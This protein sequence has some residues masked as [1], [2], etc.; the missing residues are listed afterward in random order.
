[1]LTLQHQVGYEQ[2]VFPRIP[3]AKGICGRV[4]STGKPVLLQ[5]VHT[6][7]EFLAA[8]EDIV[9]EVC[10][11]L[12]DQGKV[13]GVLNVETTEGAVLGDDDLRMMTSLSEQV[14]I[15]ISKAR[16]FSSLTQEK[17]RLELLYHLA[18]QLS[19]SLDM[20]QIAQRATDGI[21]AFTGASGGSVM[22]HVEDDRM[23]LVAFSGHSE[24]INSVNERY[25]PRIGKGLTSWVAAHQQ[26]ALVDDVT[27]DE[28]WLFVPGL[29]DVTRS[30]IS[31]PLVSGDEL[32]GVLSFASDRVAFFNQDHLRL[33]ESAATG[34]A[35]AIANARLYQEATRSLARL[36]ALSEISRAVSSSLDPAQ[37]LTT[38]ARYAAEL[39]NSD[40]AGIFEYDQEEQR[41]FISASY[42]T[43][44]EFTQ[45]VNNANIKIGQGA[46]GQAAATLQPAQ[47]MDTQ[48]TPNY[49]YSQ[50][51]AIE[52]YCSI[53][54]VPMLSRDKLL[55]GIVLWREHRK[56]F[57]QDAIEL[58]SIL[59]D[60]SVVAI[61]NARLYREASRRLKEVSLIQS[62]AL[63]GA[64]GYPF[65]DI[66]DE[67]T[68][69]I[70][71]LWDSH[72]LGFLFPDETGA[73][74]M[75]PSYCG[76]SVE[77][78]QALRL[79]PGEG[80]T[81]WAFQRAQAVVVSN[82]RQDPR[83][84][85]TDS[86]TL[87]EMDAPL[88]VGERPIGVVNVESQR[89]NAF[90]ISDLQLLSTLAGQLAV[91]LDNAQ[92]HRD[93]ADRARQLEEAYNRLAEAEELKDQLVQN[94]SHE[95][96]TP[97]TYIKGYTEL[98]L[99]EAFGTL[100]PALRE[101][102]ETVNQKT[103]AVARLVRRIV[104]L[105]AMNPL[106]LSLEPLA[107]PDLLGEATESW[108]LQAQRSDIEI[109]LD[110][111][112]QL[113]PIAGDRKQ[114]LEAFDNLFSNAIKFS[115]RGGQVHVTAHREAELVHIALSDTGIGIP[116]DKLSR[117]FDR[118]YQVDGTT[119]RRFG[120]AGVGLALVRQIVE[121]HG[122]H[123]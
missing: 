95:L 25:Q 18:R 9:S 68:D 105:Q 52:N 26:S 32:V 17:S 35:V 59:A 21:R 30:A 46:I 55:G 29:G 78:R 110:L 79:Q 40:A 7:P 117:V 118:F 57:D 28:R 102:L 99:T 23:Q 64:A 11:P 51:A 3:I 91:I 101:P 100:P 112:D 107:L 39:G 77:L 6:D 60:Q 45:A 114:L 89:P 120:G 8:M 33:V 74:Q 71:R 61:E 2:Q 82:V 38:I 54:A 63:A 1:M 80:L 13:V 106:S 116:S 43:G 72:H 41:L 113:P 73:L 94:I 12:L 121:A 83:Y 44:L 20:Q 65:D 69:L 98:M 75:H 5:D 48:N 108:S 19:S 34:V 56:P 67:A 76:L 86:T 90:S 10:V 87:S 119:R 24:S 31:V 49:P 85:E 66:V 111:P 88:L 53:L 97:M 103:E 96:R 81:G 123:V 16:L 92:A 4:A 84:V 27:K 109:S 42:N 37:V 70:G 58:L 50:I 62:V 122:G 47:I 14:G 115:P 93:L 15:A 22:V 36:Q 104:A